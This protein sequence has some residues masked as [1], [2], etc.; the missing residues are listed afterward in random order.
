MTQNHVR[1]TFLP[2]FREF[3]EK[4]DFQIDFQTNDTLKELV[5]KLIEDFGPKFKETLLNKQNKIHEWIS[6]MIDGTTI[7]T[8]EDSGFSHPLSHRQ[9]V[10]FCAFMSGG[11]RKMK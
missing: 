2:P 1:V 7:S 3:S 5:E 10:V 9:E 4:R 8:K 6:V 11:T